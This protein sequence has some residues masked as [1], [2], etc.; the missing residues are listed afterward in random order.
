MKFDF[1]ITLENNLNWCIP[2]VGNTP[3][4][5]PHS[6]GTLPFE[7]PNSLLLIPGFLPPLYLHPIH[8]EETPNTRNNWINCW[9]K[10]TTSLSAPNIG[11][12]WKVLKQNPDQAVHFPPSSSPHHLC[13]HSQFATAELISVGVTTTPTHLPLPLTLNCRNLLRICNPEEEYITCIT[14]TLQNL[15]SQSRVSSQDNHQ[16]GPTLRRSRR[17][18]PQRA[19]QTV[20]ETDLT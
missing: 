18:V 11:I 1:L 9:T 4:S 19:N 12:L 20:S 17:V 13:P 6:S 3:T 14:A 15:A 5:G 16:E 8:W 2:T 10:P 7:T